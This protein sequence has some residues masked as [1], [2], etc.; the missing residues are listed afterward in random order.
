M[1]KRKLS[2]VEKEMLY[3]LKK[4][5]KSCNLNKYKHMCTGIYERKFDKV[6][7][8]DAFVFTFS[9]YISDFF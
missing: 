6:K 2:L 8:R 3:S 5:L 1:E 4:N 9:L 7:N